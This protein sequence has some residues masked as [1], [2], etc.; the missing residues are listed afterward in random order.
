MVE[1]FFFKKKERKL[2][3]EPVVEIEMAERNQNI[4]LQF[5]D[6][7]KHNQF[8]LYFERLKINKLI[9]K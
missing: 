7:V 9:I 1:N 8:F 6:K 5:V 2:F 3:S 4:L